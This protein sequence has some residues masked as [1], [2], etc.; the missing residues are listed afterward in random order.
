LDFHSD[1]QSIRFAIKKPGTY[2]AEVKIESFPLQICDY[3]FAVYCRFG[4]LLLDDVMEGLRVEVA[5]G[6]HTPN[7]MIHKYP[8]V[9]L[10]S[11]WR[12][13]SVDDRVVER[14]TV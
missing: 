2:V 5:R 4:D 7:F 10:S 8:S 6:P 12:L 1:E 9:R 3:A 13:E 11:K 14:S